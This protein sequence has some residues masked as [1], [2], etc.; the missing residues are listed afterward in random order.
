MMFD[1]PGA[2]AELNRLGA[3]GIPCI[4][5]IDFEMEA[6]LVLPLRE[7]RADAILYDFRGKRNFTASTGAISEGIELFPRPVPFERY[8]EMFQTVFRHIDAGNSYLVNLTVPTPVESPHSLRDIFHASAA[9]Y[10]LLVE[11]RF[12]VFSPECFV[13][14]EDGMIATFP[15]KGTIDAAVPDAEQTILTDPKEAAE[16]VT[17]TDLL[18]NDLSMVASDVAVKSFRYT[19][20]I[21][22]TGRELIQVSTCIEGRLPAD[23]P[24]RLGDILFALLPAGS[25][26]GAPKRKTLGIIRSAENGPRGYYTGIAGIFDG[27]AVDSCVLIRFIESSGGT[28]VYRSGGGIT[29]GSEPRKEYQELLDKIYVPVA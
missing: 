13:R 7:V 14:M 16:Q 4:F 19:E 1:R 28:L 15:M 6:P 27:R 11:G 29:A 26:T 5:I 12:V 24:D 20:R 21:R 17:V 23:Y 3:A 10:R 18:R 9:K 2:A 22:S 8:E 25:V